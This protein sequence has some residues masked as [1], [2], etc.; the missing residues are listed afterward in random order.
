MP[1]ATPL[2]RRL[3][4]TLGVY[5][6]VVHGYQYKPACRAF[7]TT[8]CFAKLPCL[9]ATLA[10][11]SSCRSNSA[12]AVRPASL[13]ASARP[14]SCHQSLLTVTAPCIQAW[15]CQASK[16]TS[17]SHEIL[18]FKRRS[19][20]T[21]C[22]LPVSQRLKPQSS[23]PARFCTSPLASARAASLPFVGAQSRRTSL[24]V[25]PSKQ[26]RVGSQQTPN[27]SFKRTRLRRSA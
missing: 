18:P 1:R 21:S 20:S 17:F 9:H 23:M 19:L 6:L 2:S 8:P 25:S 15:A 11:P 26:E 13:A 24:R 5:G 7:T 22:E 14:S 12:R 27:P 3:S 4:Q 10:L 16:T